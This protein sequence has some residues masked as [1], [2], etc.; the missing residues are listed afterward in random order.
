MTQTT[1]SKD[2]GEFLDPTSLNA[3]EYFNIHLWLRCRLMLITA[4]NTQIRGIGVMKE[5]DMTDRL[6]LI[7]EMCMEARSVDDTELLAEFLMQ[8]VILGLQEKHLKAD[9]IGHLQEIIHLLEGS[10]FLSIRSWLTL[11][12]SLILLDDLTKAEKFKQA[13]S[14]EDML[15]LLNQAHNI[16]ITQMLIFGESIE[17]P[18]SG[19]D[20]ANPVQPLKNIYIPHTMLLAKIKLRIGH[21]LSKQVYSNIKKKDTTKWQ[22]ALHIFEMA[23]KLCQA[24][25][26]EE[27]ELEAE[28]LFRKG[29]IE[30]QILMEEKSPVSQVESFFEAIQISLRND[31]NSGLIRDSYLEIALMYF[32]LKKPRKRVS[33]APL[34]LQ[35]M[36]K[37][38]SSIKEPIASRFEMYSSLAWIAI[39]AAAQVSEA[40]LATNLLI[41]KKNARTDEVSH[42]A[43]PNIPEFATVDLLSSYTDYLLENYQVAFQTGSSLYLNEDIYDSVDSKR[44]GHN[45]ADITWILLIRYHIHL[46]RINNMSKLLASA[47]PVSGISLPDD[48]LFTSLYNSELIL[49]QKE[50]HLFLK[51]F[52]QLYSSACVEGFPRELLQDLENPAPLE[53]VLCD[54]SGKVHQDSSVQSDISGKLFGSPSYTD[55]SSEMAV[56]A[57]NKE[58]CFQWYM[59]PLDKPPKDTEPMVLLLYAY[60]LIPL[61]ISDI[62]VPTGNNVCVGTSW[63]PLN[64]V[65]SI[66]E[67][68]SNL[69]QIAELSLP[70]VPEIAS[71]ENIYEAVEPEDKS[72]DTEMEESSTLPTTFC[73]EMLSL[74]LSHLRGSKV[75]RGAQSSDLINIDQSH[76]VYMRFTSQP[77]QHSVAEAK[78]LLDRC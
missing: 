44:K 7:N 17:F 34:T 75:M 21:T 61:K 23:L 72:A 47:T 2:E 18:L 29:R 50:M 8:A 65:I 26:A 31:Q 16:L 57:L 10:E 46:Q 9:I 55:L 22:P 58:L 73:L 37:R 30:R 59:P 60:N 56:E 53:K 49:R 74:A 52:L 28:I 14:K 5:N 15:A 39:R 33:A 43:L 36:A 70:S 68:L 13:S 62:K 45:K 40:V 35:P 76:S 54:T 32:H 25:S 4:F 78:F 3:R 6:S 24:T 63:I 11:A 12:K 64:R 66:H 27:Y 71:E 20:Y 67:K 69:A 1:E 41:G 51:R 77:E 42:V 48:M 38:H 19:A